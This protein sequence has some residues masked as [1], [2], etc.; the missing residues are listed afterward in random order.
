[1]R[2]SPLIR[3]LIAFLAILA[4]G[5]PL[6]RLTGE[7][8]APGVAAPTPAPAAE[9]EVELQIT[10]TTAPKSFS[11]RHLG[12]AV[13]TATS[14]ETTVEGKLALSYPAEGIELQFGADF[15][16]GAPVA[17]ARLVLTDPAGDRHE[18]SVWG[19]GHIDEVVA[20]P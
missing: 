10:F 13:W 3:A 15:P 19:T 16:A 4:L 7:S 1:M 5:Y 9:R 14:G 18:K 17:A 11:L 6:R 12:K 8:A 2:G 20:F